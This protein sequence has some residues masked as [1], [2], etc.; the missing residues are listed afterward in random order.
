[1][2]DFFYPQFQVVYID[3]DGVRVPVPNESFDVNNITTPA[4]LDPVTSDAEGVIAEAGISDM[5]PVALHD[6]IEFSHAT[7]PNTIRF[8][9]KA[10]QEEAYTAVENNASAYIVQDDRASTTNTNY[11]E[12]FITDLDSPT[13]GPVRLG[14]GQAGVENRFN[15]P[16][17][18]SKNLRLT[19]ISQD[20]KGQYGEIDFG[21]AESDDLVIAAPTA[22]YGSISGITTNRLLGR[23]TAGTGV[24][25]LVSLGS[26][27]SFV[28]GALTLA[29]ALTIGNPVASGGANRVLFEDASQNFAANANLTF[30]GTTLT[31]DNTSNAKALVIQG[32][33]TQT[34]NLTE[35]QKSTGVEL[36]GIFQDSSGYGALRLYAGNAPVHGV[37]ICTDAADTAFFYAAGTSNLCQFVAK[38]FGGNSIYQAFDVTNYHAPEIRANFNGAIILKAGAGVSGSEYVKADIPIAIGVGAFPSAKFQVRGTTEQIRVEYDASNYY[39][40]TVG[41]TGGVTLDAVGSGSKFTFSDDVEVPDE[42]YGA[43]WNGSTEVPT[44]NAI[45]DKIET[46]VGAGTSGTYTPTRSAEVNTATVTMSQAQYMQVGNTVTVSGRFTADPVL[47][48]TATSF[49]I[50]LPVAASIVSVEEIAG[51]AFC[52]DVAGMGAAIIGSVAN[53]TAVFKWVAT[54]INSQSWSYMFTYSI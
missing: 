36:V 41:S 46:F 47:V 26:G 12:I 18:A 48:A 30:D 3:A 39:K 17:T 11:G 42:V 53:D 21:K 23:Y 34:A 7:Y 19:L 10:T 44:K 13:R 16:V 35:W 2:A 25:E 1:M 49:E 9:V 24:A 32:H 15:Y 29:N 45:Y 5:E 28:S 37:D 40:V 27:L 52:G 22:S 31:I 38:S 43:G 54:D 14:R 20:E 8:T 33:S 51:V 50:T 6:I 4:A